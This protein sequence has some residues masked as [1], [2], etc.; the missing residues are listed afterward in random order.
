MS[1]VPGERSADQIRVDMVRE[2]GE[3][4]ESMTS[5]R[6]RWAEVT[7]WRGQLREHREELVIGGIAAGLLVGGAIALRHRDQS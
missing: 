2:R 1:S 7:D 5:L 3:L 6:T 4:S